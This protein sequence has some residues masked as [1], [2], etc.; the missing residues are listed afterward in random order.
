MNNMCNILRCEGLVRSL[1]NFQLKNLNEY[2]ENYNKKSF[3][4]SLNIEFK[5][6]VDLKCV[7]QG[8]H[9]GFVQH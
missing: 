8:F 3:L 5:N 1:I 9:I 2:L 6:H 7:S 4:L